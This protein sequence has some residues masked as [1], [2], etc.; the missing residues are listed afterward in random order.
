MRRVSF[1]E[2]RQQQHG[3]KSFDPAQDGS[4]LHSSRKQISPLRVPKG[5]SGR[6]DNVV[7]GLMKY[8]IMTF[9]MAVCIACFL[10]SLA[11]VSSGGQYH[12]DWYTIDGGGGTS[13]G[14]QYVL[15]G[16]IGQPN[17]GYSSSGKYELLGGFW[18][19]GSAVCIVDFGE[20]AAFC[21]HWLETGVGIKA[22]LDKNQKIDFVDYSIL[23]N[24]CLGGCPFP[25]ELK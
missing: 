25:W 21:D 2:S 14:G 12:I 17:A 23:V 22:D 3:L 5:R 1:I 7:A 11:S 6:N 19:G 4:I 16:T 20:L 13:T 8:R 24:L 10:L 9:V 18:S 15:V